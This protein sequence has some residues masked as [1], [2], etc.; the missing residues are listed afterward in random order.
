MTTDAM[1]RRNFCAAMGASALAFG[2]LAM[3]ATTAEAAPAA[4]WD[5]TWVDR[6]TAKYR[7]VFDTPDLNDGTVFDNVSVFLSGYKEVYQAADA[8]LQ[9]VVVL[10][11]RG[12]HLAFNDALWE[13]YKLGEELKTGANKNPYLGRLAN[14]RQRN[15]ILLGCNLAASYYARGMASRAGADFNT[16]FNEVKANLAPGVIL[17]P[18]GVFATIR[19]QQAGCWFMKSA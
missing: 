11:A 6:L 15:A 19:A 7:V 8:D 12:V 2:G 3:N 17:M 1:D 13:K 16:V 4:E 5:M 14:L 9:P 18:S 10:R